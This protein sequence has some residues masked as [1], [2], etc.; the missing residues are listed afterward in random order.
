M[1][2]LEW[3]LQFI[4]TVPR[5]KWTKQNKTLYLFFIYPEEG[6]TMLYFILGM[7]FAIL[8]VTILSSLAEL[9]SNATNLLIAKMAA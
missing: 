8:G 5:K 6:D 7:I 2:T 1:T 9:V 3:S 4:I